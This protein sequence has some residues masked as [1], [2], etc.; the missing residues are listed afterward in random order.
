[1]IQSNHKKTKLLNTAAPVAELK[2]VAHQMPAP[3]ATADATQNANHSNRCSCCGNCV[4][5]TCSSLSCSSCMVVMDSARTNCG[6]AGGAVG[7]STSCSCTLSG[8]DRTKA[9]RDCKDCASCR[10]CCH[11]SPL[12]GMLRVKGRTPRCCCGGGQV[13]SRAWPQSC[14]CCNITLCFRECERCAAGDR[15]GTTC[16][17]WVVSVMRRDTLG[18]RRGGERHLTH[19]ELTLCAYTEH[20]KPHT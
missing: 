18:C 15:L 19:R 13:C 2:P 10:C 9:E 14:R 8:A 3:N 12:G 11:A 5:R 6:C 20:Q 1:M 4:V 7:L 16:S 17:G